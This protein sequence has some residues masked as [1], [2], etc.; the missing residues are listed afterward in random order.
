MLGHFHI[1][2]NHRMFTDI[3]RPDIYL[4]EDIFSKF[5]T[6]VL[7]VKDSTAYSAVASQ[8]KYERLFWKKVRNMKRS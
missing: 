3:H 5:F 2:D 4:F 1:C 8:M 6:P 7:M